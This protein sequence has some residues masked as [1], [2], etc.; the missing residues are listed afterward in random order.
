MLQR[1]PIPSYIGPQFKW[2][3]IAY[4]HFCNSDKVK[5]FFTLSNISPL[6]FLSL[7]YCYYGTAITITTKRF[8]I[9]VI[10]SKTENVEVNKNCA[11]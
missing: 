4:L 1:I 11:F 7:I 5:H 2:A 6:Q 10:N 9:Q 8:V 3:Y